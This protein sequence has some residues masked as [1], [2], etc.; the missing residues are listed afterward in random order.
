MRNIQI[1]VRVKILWML[2]NKE[3][4]ASTEI[5]SSE[6]TI[7]HQILRL[8]QSHDEVIVTWSGVWPQA[9]RIP[10]PPT[11]NLPR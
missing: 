10:H 2:E 4:V 9:L 5:M 3:V 8:G 1:Y 6:A 11:M 7:D